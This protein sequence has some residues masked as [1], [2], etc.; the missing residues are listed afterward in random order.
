[1]RSLRLW[2]VAVPLLCGASRVADAQD[3]PEA[4]FITIEDSQ[5]AGISGFRELWDKPQPGALVFDAVHRS[6]LVRF[7][8]AAERTAEQVRRGYRIEKVELLLTFKD[9]ELDARPIGYR[10]RWGW[11]VKDLYEKRKPRWHAVAWAL[12]RPWQADAKTGPTFNANVAGSRYWSRFGATDTSEDRFP[13][14]FGP[15]EVSH[16]HAFGVVDEVTGRKPETKPSETAQPAGMDITAVLTD[17]AFG[18]SVA[19]RLRAFA[20]CG[21]LVRKWE[22]YDFR[23]RHPFYGYGWGQGA[24]GRGL[25]IERPKLRVT[26]APDPAA[27][28][29]LGQLPPATDLRRLPKRGDP[30]CVVP[31]KREHAANMKRLG[32]TKPA[33]M[34]DWQWRR[35]RELSKLGGGYPLPADYDAYLDWLDKRLA[36]PP[37]F[38]GG[39][40]QPDRLLAW[41]LYREAMPPYVA[42]H[43][44]PTYWNA[45]LMP[46]VPTEKLV[47]PMSGVAERQDQ[48]GSVPYYKRT[49]DWRGNCSFYRGAYHYQ[50][51]TMNFNNTIA[52]SA[53]VAGGIAKAERAIADGRHGLEHFPLRFWS[54]FDGAL[55]EA[56]DHYYFAI[57]LSAQKM[58][59][60]FAPTPLDRLMARRCMTKSLDEVTS[61]WHPGLRRFIANSDRTSMRHL[62]VTQTGLVHVVHTMSTDGALHDL[63]NPRRPGN[64]PVIGHNVPPARIAQQTA[65]SPWAP[66]WV[67]HMINDKPIPFELTALY[68]MA[69]RFRRTP[70]WRKAYLGRHYG[71]A[72]L[73]VSC[74]DECIPALVQWRRTDRPVENAEDVVT[75]LVRYGINTTN[76][77]KVSGTT[78]GYN[79]L[80]DPNGFTLTTPEGVRVTADGKL[81]LAMIAVQPKQNRIR[82]DHVLKD[83]QKGKAGMATAL[84]VFGLAKPPTIVFNGK[85]LPGKPALIQVDGKSAY[86]IPLE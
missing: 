66:A 22:T 80:P 85:W 14:R 6:L 69:H 49:G 27:A 64:L 56:I 26:L 1:M 40:D 63:S 78:A 25:V 15:T 71:M 2:M 76:L 4:I 51:G 74:L 62:F 58:A 57:T 35:V 55:L 45:F 37:R 13:T 12:R 59:A 44:G 48:E 34:P 30:T 7:P 72:S 84:R 83:D 18:R 52:M 39:W 24:G 16:Y 75:M 28:R 21:L 53:L 50:L 10:Q 3:N 33:W 42:E 5:T 79:P 9:A 70:L 29:S 8:D 31:D 47:H 67:A 41:L 20:D 38:M 11:G 19:E 65:V 60:D 43:Y 77:V 32:L 17:P 86:S 81:G 73:D 46:E 36:D 23:F 68:T 61:A 54:W 82:I